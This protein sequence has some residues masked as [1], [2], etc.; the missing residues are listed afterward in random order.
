MTCHL[1]RMLPGLCVLVLAACSVQYQDLSQPIVGQS[2]E[3][4]WTKPAVGQWWCVSVDPGLPVLQHP[5][6]GPVIGYTRDVVA[7]FGMQVGQH[8]SIV[9]YNGLIGWIEMSQVR[10]YQ[11]RRPSSTCVIEGVDFQQRPI[12]LIR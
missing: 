3:F 8:I 10:P 6:G 9:Y 7:I 12:F 11:G 2:Q 1:C 4:H 5:G